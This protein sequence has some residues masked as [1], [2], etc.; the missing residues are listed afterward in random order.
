MIC[1]P[2]ISIESFTPGD[3]QKFGFYE[4]PIHD[5]NENVYGKN[6]LQYCVETLDII[7]IS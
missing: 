5:I 6:Q 2:P 7:Q 4:I 1:F 3:T